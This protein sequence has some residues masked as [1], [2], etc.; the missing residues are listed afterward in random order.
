MVEKPQT[1][2]SG[3]SAFTQGSRPQGCKP[4]FPKG[5]DIGQ[6]QICFLSRCGHPCHQL[7]KEFPAL[8]LALL[9]AVFLYQNIIPRLSKM[10]MSLSGTALASFRS[11][12]SHM[13]V[14]KSL[15]QAQPSHI[16]RSLGTGQKCSLSGLTNTY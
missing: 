15:L 12:Y 4:T 10:T 11:F 16:T 2:P 1:S 8:F 7:S 14:Y 6:G 13:C 5:S 3:I 9:C